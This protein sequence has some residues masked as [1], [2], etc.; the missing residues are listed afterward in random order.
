[1]ILINLVYNSIVIHYKELQRPTVNQQGNNKV[2]TMT[3]IKKLT[4]IPE[5]NPELEALLPRLDALLRKLLVHAKEQ[6][7]DEAGIMLLAVFECFHELLAIGAS[8][9]MAMAAINKA[10]GDNNDQ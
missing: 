7:D 3:N 8:G 6:G 4:D 2:I 5:D 1:M 10:M 9:P